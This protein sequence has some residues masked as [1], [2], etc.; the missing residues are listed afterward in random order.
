MDSDGDGTLSKEELIKG[1]YKI[2][3]FCIFFRVFKIL[4]KLLISN[5]LGRKFIIRN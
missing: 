5:K 3:I 1:I 4:W 2:F